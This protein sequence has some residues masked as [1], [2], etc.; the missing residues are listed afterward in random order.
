[1]NKNF[2][3]LINIIIFIIIFQHTLSTE[4]INEYPES[5]ECLTDCCNYQPDRP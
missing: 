5:N 4:I 3:M 2:F 1:M